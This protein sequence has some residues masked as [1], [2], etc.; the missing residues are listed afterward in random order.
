MEQF[1]KIFINDATELINDLEEATLAFENKPD[2]VEIVGRIFRVMHTLKGS[3]TMF[4]FDSISQYTHDLEN[5]FELIREKKISANPDLIEIT[6]KSIDH[7]KDLLNYPQLNNKK[8][9]AN[10]NALLIK[11]NNIIQQYKIHELIGPDSNKEKE[12]SKNATI[13]EKTFL[14]AFKPEPDI[15]LNGTNPLYLLSDLNDLG[16]SVILKNTK[17]LPSFQDLDV[18]LSYIHWNILLA[19][20]EPEDKIRDVFI[21]VEDD[22]NLD[23]KVIAEYNL[24]NNDEFVNYVKQIKNS[25]SE[26]YTI[27]YE[28]IQSLKINLTDKDKK[29]H[30]QEKVEKSDTEKP[31]KITNQDVIKTHKD[32]I[33]VSSEKIDE[34]MNLV[35]E[36][37]TSQAELNLI[38][39]QNKNLR[40]TKVSENIEKIARQLRDNALNICLIPINDFVINYQRMVRDLSAELGKQIKLVTQGTETELD[41]RIIDSLKDPFL[42]I[43]RNAI[44]HGIEKEEERKLKDKPEHGTILLKAFYSG[45]E[46]H[47]Q[48]SDDGKGIDLERVK[49]KALDKGLI[50]A[51]TKYTNKEI[52]DLVFLPG[53]STSSVVTDISG[54]GVGMDV[55][56]RKIEEINGTVE[57]SSEKDKGTTVTVK[58][59]LSLS[60][61][62]T[63]L[64]R[65]ADELFLIPLHLIEKCHEI[66][67]QN[68]ISNFNQFII[69]NGEQIPF[70]YLREIFDLK[71]NTPKI[72]RIIVFRHYDKKIALIVD[73][74]VG[75][76]QA[77]LKPLGDIYKTLE[78]FSGASIMGNGD[79]ALVLDTN[80]LVQKYQTKNSKEI[81]TN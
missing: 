64:V 27:I 37:V 47:I 66:F 11:I 77:V 5:I 7:L 58:L 41:K 49:Q 29:L 10:H 55:V 63:L 67:H 42:H 21:F 1:K 60:I 24:L 76:H 70:I 33:K 48:I 28:K 74:I 80:K 31:E 6:F 45:A 44:D 78:I 8:I 72:E 50:N 13:P 65:I 25:E 30:S 81:I 34:L 16:Q 61:I 15:F 38:A 79:I 22:A 73:S 62:D 68:L 36:L 46:V 20:S 3:S 56:K 71:N 23:I 75:E 4:G 18:R 57:I 51:T 32:A 52:Y 2:D 43:L 17:K 9:K 53:F 19:T 69:H 40:L 39:R 14:I 59:P 26:I 35:S 54:R 12:S